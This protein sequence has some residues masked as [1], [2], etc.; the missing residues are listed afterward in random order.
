MGP[1]RLR[2]TPYHKAQNDQASRRKNKCSNQRIAFQ[3]VQHDLPP[4]KQSNRGIYNQQNSANQQESEKNDDVNHV[5]AHFAVT[6]NTSAKT[7]GS[8][9]QEITNSTFGFLSTQMKKNSIFPLTPPVLPS[10]EF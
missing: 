8:L 6:S 1:R 3:P 10:G 7:P 5:V 4:S 2:F 9:H